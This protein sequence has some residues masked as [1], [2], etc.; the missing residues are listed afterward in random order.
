MWRLN[1]PN[2]HDQYPDSLVRKSEG[3]SW[4]QSGIKASICMNRR[5]RIRSPLGRTLSTSNCFAFGSPAEARGLS[6]H[7]GSFSAHMNSHYHMETSLFCLHFM[8]IN[9]QIPHPSVEEQAH[10]ENLNQSTSI[11]PNL[12]LSE[13]LDCYFAHLTSSLNALGTLAVKKV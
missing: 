12:R 3:V 13:V 1:L 8:Y 11:P 4:P 7:M 2:H 6:A 10:N 9:P 5:C